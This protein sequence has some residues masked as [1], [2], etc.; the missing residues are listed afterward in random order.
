MKT[1]LPFLLCALLA[2]A[3]CALAVSPAD[4]TYEGE[5]AGFSELVPIKVTLTF[6]GGVLVDAA[7]AGEGEHLDYAED[8]LVELPRRMVAQGTVEVDSITGV[9]WTCRGIL[10]AARAARDQAEQAG[11]EK[12]N[13]G[14]TA[15]RT[16]ETAVEGFRWGEALDTVLNTKGA[17]RV[18]IRNTDGS[19]TLR[20]QTLLLERSLPLSL[21]FR[22]GRLVGAVYTG[23]G[24]GDFQAFSE[25]IQRKYGP[26]LLL[27]TGEKPRLL[28]VSGDTFIQL[29][30]A[31]AGGLTLV[32]EPYLQVPAEGPGWSSDQ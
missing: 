1:I 24:S 8:A 3:P 4:G 11:A 21:T 17:P 7:A 22:Q 28:H 31:G 19:E 25:A 23:L 29:A 9:T 18:R 14:L 5:A 30:Q 12:N 32:F 20:Y 13:L 26:P 6:A 2:L 10:A 15:R 27:E 16:Y